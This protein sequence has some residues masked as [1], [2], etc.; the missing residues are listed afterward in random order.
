MEVW[1]AQKRHFDS[2]DCE[3][4]TKEAGRGAAANDR[5]GTPESL[6]ASRG[7]ESESITK[8]YMLR[9]LENFS[10]LTFRIAGMEEEKAVPFKKKSHQIFFGSFSC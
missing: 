4:S 10:G 3:K 6:F 2:F 5:E 8:T 1:V 9:P 7:H